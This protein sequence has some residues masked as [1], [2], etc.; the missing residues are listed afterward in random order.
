MD[1]WKQSRS[2]QS[3]RW[4]A[5]DYLELLA[6]LG[7]KDRPPT[8]GGL[9]FDVLIIGSGYG[10][11]IAADALSGCTDDAGRTFRVGLLERGRE[12]LPGS[13]PARMAD[14]PTEVRGSF[15]G[16]SRGGEA[17]FDVRVGADLSVVLANG[18]G[19]GSL[20]NAGVMEIP[21]AR[22]FG[23][24]WPSF[25]HQPA[26]RQ[27]LFSEA[28]RLLGASV[29]DGSN[30]DLGKS[31]SEMPPKTRVL[32]DMAAQDGPSAERPHAFR[33]AAITVALND[34]T[35]IG[36]VQLKA[37]K[38]CGDCATGCNYS[39][40]ESLDTNLLARAQRRGVE[41]YCGA[42]V[43]RVARAEGSQRG[44]RVQTTPTDEKL[45][46]RQGE[47]RWVSATR[48]IL[49]AGTLG[50]TEILLRS[51]EQPEPTAEPGSTRP[52]TLRFS[53][54]LGQRFSGNGDLIH[55][56][57]NHPP[58][59]NA[60]ADED[61]LPAQRGV[62]PTITGI[63]DA[64]VCLENQAPQKITI[65]DL[66]IPGPLRRFTEELLTTADTLQALGEFDGSVHIEGHPADDPF[67]VQPDKIKRTSVFAVMG[68]DGAGG[69]MRLADTARADAAQGDGHLLVHWPELK[70]HP[71]F[72]AQQEKLEKLANVLGSGGRQI[73]NPL[74]KPLTPTMER[75]IG[76]AR[77]PLLS[78]HPLG[79][80]AMGI[81]RNAGVVNEYGE[82]FDANASSE[83]AV[84]EGLLVLDGAIVP[85]ALATNPAL[86]IAAVSLRAMKYHLP[87]W[88]FTRDPRISERAARPVTRPQ[89]AD[90]EA[91]IRARRDADPEPTKAKF[92][93]RLTGALTLR[94]SQGEPEDCVAELTLTYDE[95]PLQNL[96]R[97]DTEGRLSAARLVVGPDGDKPAGVLS[98]YPRQLW[99]DHSDLW[100]NDAWRDP[101]TSPAR[102]YAVAGTLTVLHREPS[103]PFGR[104]LRGLKAWVPT[105]GLRDLVQEVRDH[106]R[107]RR[108]GFP[109][110]KL[111]VAGRIRD[112][113]SLASRAGEVRLFEYDLQV[114][115]EI[116]SS[117]ESPRFTPQTPLEGAKIE[118]Q[119]HITYSRPSNPWRQLQEL[120]LTRFPGLEPRDRPPV[121]KLD[122]AYFAAHGVPLLQI[123]RQREHLE[124][125]AD[126]ASLMAYFARM[127]LTIHLWNLRKPDTPTPRQINRLPGTLPGLPAP[128]IHRIE[129]DRLDGQPVEIQLTRY[130]LEAVRTGAQVAEGPPVVLIHGY[131]ASGTTFAHP[132]LKPGLARYLAQAGHDVW[133]L[134]LRTSC[135]LPTA[136]HPWTFERV[137]LTDI[138]AA[139]DHICFKSGAAQVDVLAHCMGAAMLSMAVL[140]ASQSMADV[141][142]GRETG[143]GMPVVDRF[144]VQR[145]RLPKRI[146]RIVLSQVGPL[147]VLSPENIFRAYVLSFVEQL[148]GRVD[149]RFRTGEDEGL[150]AQLLDRLLASVPYPDD[151]IG[152]ENPRWPF[153]KT[154]YVGT[155]H[156]MDA[157]YGRTFKLANMHRETLEQIDDFFG[158]LSL[159][160]VSQVMHF[161]RTRTITNRA[162][163]NRLVSAHKLRT[164]WRYPTLSLHGA[165]N[166]LADP[167]TVQRLRRRLKEEAGCDWE[168]L[169][170]PE[171]GHQD[172]LIGIRVEDGFAKVLDYLRESD[173]ARAQR[174]LSVQSQ[175]T[176]VVPVSDTYRFNPHPPALGPVLSPHHLPAATGRHPLWMSLG[177]PSELGRP[178]V[179]CF[180]A[181]H[182]DRA[183]QW[184][185]DPQ[186]RQ[187]ERMP[188]RYDPSWVSVPLPPWAAEADVDHLAVWLL[189]AEGPSW[190]QGVTEASQH[191]LERAIDIGV[192]R[193]NRDKGF[194]PALVYLP[195]ATVGT[196][197][198]P[199]HL[200]LGS[201]QYAPGL[202]DTPPAYAAWRGLNERLQSGQVP[203]LDLLVLAGDQVYTDATAGL[204]DPAQ[205]DDRYRRPYEK[206]L[207]DP[208]VR[209]L[210]QRV[211]LVTTLDDHELDD[212]WEPLAPGWSPERDKANWLRRRDGLAAFRQFQR[213]GTT[214]PADGALPPSWFPLQVRGV[215]MFLLDTRSERRHRAAGLAAPGNIMLPRQWQALQQWLVEAPATRP[216]VIVSPS[217]L[218]PRHRNAVPARL[219]FGARDRGDAATL[220]SDSWDGYPVNLFGLLQQIADSEIRGVV[221]L[222]GDEHLGLFSRITVQAVGKAPVTIFSVHA[223]GLYTPYRFAN[224]Y[225][226]EFVPDESFRFWSDRR[227]R[228]RCK[229]QTTLF[230]EAGFVH[231]SLLPQADAGWSLRCETATGRWLAEEKL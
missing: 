160:T 180:V 82:V 28:K 193:L 73:P 11:A 165:E 91:E 137:A 151:E 216:K 4:L 75:F 58:T 206:W 173:A 220:R 68:D 179:I 25:W 188:K 99:T 78:V 120:T 208:D 126:A 134:D 166:G 45:R 185:A 33:P 103:S 221:L 1:S 47:P 198:T 46:A 93:E 189:Y 71:L 35:T 44:W 37:C 23:Q 142:S 57:Y 94:N 55:F 212:N 121:L 6:S 143:R 50:S 224:A 105:R 147:V 122:P 69:V 145:R 8:V 102:S 184:Q 38:R 15:A 87:K 132:T 81:D 24:H 182:R 117:A 161:A 98:L 52:A 190:P 110:K 210:L 40:K 191:A 181:V 141:L 51:Q 17:L 222:S 66:A 92:S 70:N 205:A 186:R 197:D 67:A 21:D 62:G 43:L 200:A 214:V 144:A 9:D 150:G 77:G 100:P 76:E 124:A 32:L 107:L 159:D 29:E 209:A 112:A 26:E 229:V 12:Y 63:I 155:R 64:D 157:L 74:W 201:C 10:G 60:M 72:R 108:Q 202:L 230:A 88:Q 36:D 213:L 96:F 139:V 154:P 80:C 223:P 56:G 84:H 162:G 123:T 2:A 153:A 129:V 140:S 90:V 39:A 158:P 192:R 171:R 156:R 194:S 104:T 22:Q 135:G 42:T 187:V 183:G 65:E 106:L 225:P 14:L 83:T 131:S 146:R 30:N 109:G 199:L 195:R 177:A 49:S 149:Y 54:A 164:R 174:Q 211:P 61:Q 48:V 16:Q 7:S 231:V 20:I 97:P 31:R 114:L 89:L 226:A 227:Q 196:A 218:L 204:F 13:F 125:L 118:G 167:A 5:R 170:L 152:L 163:R 41:I 133:V 178:D 130:R 19:G 95:L 111:D 148:I 217:L 203:A 207:G 138:P 115:R 219:A 86:T 169:V 119:K 228:Y 27:A 172:S 18:L 136:G 176:D 79:G 116:P 127:M 85:G 168:A 53:S 128:D 101:A 3:A 34:K 59:A 215:P 175:T 113:L